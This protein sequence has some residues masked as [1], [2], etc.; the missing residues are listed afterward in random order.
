MDE[1]IYDLLRYLIISLLPSAA[2]SFGVWKIQN[3]I[4]RSQDK[5]DK[6]ESE[7]LK[8]EEC[9]EEHQVVILKSINASI[10][11]SEATAKALR[12]G[13]I[14]GEVNEALG[15]SKQIRNEQREFY[16]KQ[17]IRKII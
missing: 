10:A 7:R 13:H 16:Q 11:L 3:I 17:G 9:R 6:L 12:D 5:Q 8:L 14:N 1:L 2:V 4:K 15:Y